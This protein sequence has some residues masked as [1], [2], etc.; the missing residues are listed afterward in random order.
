[1]GTKH[2]EQ[3]KS[4]LSMA[5][6]PLYSDRLRLTFFNLRSIPPVTVCDAQRRVGS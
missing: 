3:R 5:N 6:F 4:G 2:S 1:M